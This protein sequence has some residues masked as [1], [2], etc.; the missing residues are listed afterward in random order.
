MSPPEPVSKPTTKPA[1]YTP[2]SPQQSE[3]WAHHLD[4]LALAQLQ[5][6]RHRRRWDCWTPAKAWP[7]QRVQV[8]DR[9]AHLFRAADLQW[10]HFWN[11]RCCKFVVRKSSTPPVPDHGCGL[12]SPIKPHHL[13]PPHRPAAR[14]ATRLHLRTSSTEKTNWLRS[15]IKQVP[16]R[17]A[18]SRTASASFLAFPVACCRHPVPLLLS[19]I[20]RDI[21]HARHLLQPLL[22]VPAR[23]LHKLPPNVDGPVPPKLVKQGLLRV[24]VA[25]RARL[26]RVGDDRSHLVARVVDRVDANALEALC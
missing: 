10:Y 3:G 9:I 5:S 23:T 1:A 8:R 11:K 13:S 24:E 16:H 6:M 21:V 4:N 20:H 26:A 7:L 15:A 22:R 17:T 14:V 19:Q 12:A 25:V 18:M 2:C